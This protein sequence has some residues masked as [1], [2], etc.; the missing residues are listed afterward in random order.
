MEIT[1]WIII[2]IIIG[3]G[4]VVFIVIFIYVIIPQLDKNAQPLTQDE[5]KLCEGIIQNGKGYP[6]VY[7]RAVR[8]GKCPCLPCDKLDKAK[9]P[10]S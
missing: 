8:N 5:L 3:I 7:K 10:A 1:L 2:G 6:W 4:I 9:H